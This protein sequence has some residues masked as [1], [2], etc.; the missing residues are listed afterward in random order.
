MSAVV[1]D[2]HVAVWLLVAPD[3]LSVEATSALQAAVEAGY[4]IYLASISVVEII[5]LVEKGRLPTL[6][7]ERFNDELL[8]PDSGLAV[9]PLDLA[10]AQSLRQIPRAVVPEMPDRVIAATALHWGLPLVSRDLS[11]RSV[12]DITTIW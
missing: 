10:V 9:I 8:R 7:L 3:R 12:E 11:L 6:V 4:P 5:Y 1:A 2:T